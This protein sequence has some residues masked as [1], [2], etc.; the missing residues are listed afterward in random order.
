[1]MRQKEETGRHSRRKSSRR[2]RKWRKRRW[3]KKKKW[4]SI[5]RV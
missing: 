5:R 1:M 2:K 4:R 3:K